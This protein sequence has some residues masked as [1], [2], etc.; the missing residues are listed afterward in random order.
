MISM[1]KVSI[2]GYLGKDGEKIVSPA[3]KEL[4]TFSVAVSEGKD[5]ATTWFKVVCW[6]KTAET[7][8]ERAKKGTP[9]YV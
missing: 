3:G 4:T 9:V 2:I 6:G 8:A 1:A 5:S 7:V